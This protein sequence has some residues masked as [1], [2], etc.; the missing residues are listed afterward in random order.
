MSGTR[1]NAEQQ[2]WLL[3]EGVPCVRYPS[4]STNGLQEPHRERWRS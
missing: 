1:M 2:M 3:S 4:C